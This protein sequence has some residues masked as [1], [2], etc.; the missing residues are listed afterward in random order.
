M[1]S[2]TEGAYTAD[3]EAH[4]GTTAR[5]DAYSS[6]IG[7]ELCRYTIAEWSE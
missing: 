2:D 6:A 1:E 5:I 7:S 4:E 3:K